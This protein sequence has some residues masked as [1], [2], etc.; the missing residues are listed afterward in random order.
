MDNAGLLVAVDLFGIIINVSKLG[1]HN[2]IS[3]NS[4]TM[5]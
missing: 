2:Y 4:N 1:E 5:F 3:I